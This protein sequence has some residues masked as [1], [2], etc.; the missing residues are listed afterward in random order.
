M[1]RLTWP[2]ALLGAA[3]IALLARRPGL[4]FSRAFVFIILLVGAL[5]LAGYRRR[6]RGPRGP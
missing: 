3:L 6:P 5:V 4:L 1:L 2:V